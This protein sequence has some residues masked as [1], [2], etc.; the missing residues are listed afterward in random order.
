MLLTWF[1]Y[2]LIISKEASSVACR[3]SSFSMCSR[4]SSSMACLWSSISA[5]FRF[6]VCRAR[7]SIS[8]CREAHVR[9][10]CTQAGSQDSFR[11]QRAIFVSSWKNVRGWVGVCEKD[12]PLKKHH[13][14]L[15]S[16][17]WSLNLQPLPSF[18]EVQK[19][20]ALQLPVYCQL[21]TWWPKHI[22]SC[23]LQVPLNIKEHS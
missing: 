13:Q 2:R 10:H 15:W 11:R 6:L 7:I 18:L 17:Q 14:A 9:V 3:R 19:D 20:Q 22:D 23:L 16:P 1:Q 12:I 8:S 4:S 5:S 21:Q